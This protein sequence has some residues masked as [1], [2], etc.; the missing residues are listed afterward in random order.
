MQTLK[1]NIDKISYDDKINLVKMLVEK[2]ITYVTYN[3]TFQFT[4][5]NLDTSTIEIISEYAKKCLI[6]NKKKY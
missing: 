5:N 2:K 1:D 6:K 4:L 3:T